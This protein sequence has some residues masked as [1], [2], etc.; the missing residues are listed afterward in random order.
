MRR[1]ATDRGKRA[2]ETDLHLGVTHVGRG[3]LGARYP[4]LLL[5]LHLGI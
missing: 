4:N 2:A 1:P 3:T 5:L